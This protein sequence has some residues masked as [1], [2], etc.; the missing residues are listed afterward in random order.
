MAWPIDA[1]DLRR[2][3]RDAMVATT[4]EFADQFVRT[5]VTEAMPMLRDIRFPDGLGIDDARRYHGTNLSHFSFFAWKFPSWLVTVA[6]RCPYKD[7]RES[8]LEDCI[9]EELSDLDAGGRSHIDVLFDEAAACGFDRDRV[10]ATEATPLMI[11]CLHALENFARQLPWEAAFAALSSLEV[12]QSEPAAA[13]WEQMLRDASPDGASA[14][15]VTR[16]EHFLAS[17]TGLDA[18]VLVF[19]ALHAYKDRSH[20]GRKLEKIAAYATTAEVQEQMLWG[21]RAGTMVFCLMRQEIDRLAR[22]AAGIRASRD[23]SMP[24]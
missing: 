20:G 12:L 16:D 2:P 3:A 5:V 13:M 7:V 19:A 21:A 17:R 24:E 23:G 15:P 11:A 10:A 18:E 9:D 22:E 4:A 1:R 6:T 14:R 8:I